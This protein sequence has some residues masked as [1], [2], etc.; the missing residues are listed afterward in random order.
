MT[1]SQETSDL[2]FIESPKIA[3]LPFLSY[4]AVGKN[5]T[6]ARKQLLQ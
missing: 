3:S 5:L 2:F 4:K 6:N 1:E